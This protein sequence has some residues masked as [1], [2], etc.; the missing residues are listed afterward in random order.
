MVPR[1]GYLGGEANVEASGRGRSESAASR[2]HDL[3]RVSDRVL[4][5]TVTL[6]IC[7]SNRRTAIEMNKGKLPQRAETGFASL[8]D[9]SS[10]PREK[11]QHD[12]KNTTFSNRE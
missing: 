2:A 6:F 9:R 5:N 12:D 8:H 3:L 11:I 4:F 1:S 10:V 7:S